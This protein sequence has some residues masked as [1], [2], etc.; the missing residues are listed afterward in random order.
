MYFGNDDP[1]RDL[2]EKYYMLLAEMKDFNALIDNKPAFDQPV[3]KQ[4]RGVWETY[5]N[6][7]KWR[8][9]SRKFIS[10]F[11]SSKLLQTIGID[12]TRQINTNIRQQINFTGKLEDYEGGTMFFIA[13]KQKKNSKFFFK[14]INCNGIT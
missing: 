8:F 10:L 4:K 7:K 6:V 11:V 14:F 9:Y 2:F 1:T 3:K 13:E 12:L 5:R